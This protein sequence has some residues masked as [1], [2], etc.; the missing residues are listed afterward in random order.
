MLHFSR[1]IS[2]KG[3]HVL[4]ALSGSL[5]CSLAGPRA[6]A[7]GTY[8]TSSSYR[9]DVERGSPLTFPR[10]TLSQRRS[11]CSSASANRRFFKHFF[12]ALFQVLFSF[13]FMC[14]C[15]C[16]EEDGMSGVAFRLL[17]CFLPPPCPL[18]VKVL[19]HCAEHAEEVETRH[20]LFQP[21]MRPAKA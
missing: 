15:V 11:V 18:T 17:A 8:V 14:V 4:G 3:R 1:S 2:C 10:P 19:Q 21:L 16:V 5:A 20:E 12:F 13:S 9:L 7:A 6:A